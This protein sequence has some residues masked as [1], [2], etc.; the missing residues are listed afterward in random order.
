MITFELR[1]K[2]A[3]GFSLSPKKILPT[4]EE[5]LDGL[6]SLLDTTRN[7]KLKTIKSG[8]TFKILDQIVFVFNVIFFIIVRF[9]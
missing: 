1:D 4:C 7:P 5:T 3:E 8:Q 9:D 6:I 2:G